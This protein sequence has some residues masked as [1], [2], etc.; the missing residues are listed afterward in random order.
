MV[1]KKIFMMLSMTSLFSMMAF[2]LNGDEAAAVRPFVDIVVNGLNKSLADECR[3]KTGGTEKTEVPIKTVLNGLAIDID[4]LYR[5]KIFYNDSYL[6]L[7]DAVLMA[8]KIV[9]S[10]YQKM[11]KVEKEYRKTS[12]GAEAFKDFEDNSKDAADLRKALDLARKNYNSKKDA[13]TYDKLMEAKKK[14]KSESVGALDAERKARAAYNK[15]VMRWKGSGKRKSLFDQMIQRGVFLVR[16]TWETQQLSSLLTQLFGPFIKNMIDLDASQLVNLWMDRAATV[17]RRPSL[18]AGSI[19]II[20]A[21]YA[22]HSKKSI[23][24]IKR[25]ATVESGSTTQEST[26][27]ESTT[28]E[29][30]TQQPA[31][32]TKENELVIE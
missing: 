5:R 18:K 30:T 19:N 32:T 28:R 24:Q 20:E 3:W 13:A 16:R 7:Y 2:V 6:P 27:Q 12:E 31:S 26:T 23:A 9:A 8:V 22:E 10:T 17:Q 29:S 1:N 15:K 4:N 21:Q 11:E 14:Y 25:L